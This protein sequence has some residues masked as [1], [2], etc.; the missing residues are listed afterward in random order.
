MPALGPWITLSARHNN[1]ECSGS[2]T[3]CF[4]DE[5]D[6]ATR[7]VLVLDGLIQ[8]A[9]AVMLIVGASTRSRVIARDFVGNLHFTPAQVGK[10]GYG[11]FLTGEF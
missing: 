4:R 6:A 7:T 9:G 2:G 11:G 1:S 3:P 10:H 8:T 5:S